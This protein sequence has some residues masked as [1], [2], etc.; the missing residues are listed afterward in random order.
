M[1]IDDSFL[2]KVDIFPGEQ[3]HVLNIN[4]G[5]SFCNLCYFSTARVRHRIIELTG[6]QIRYC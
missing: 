4:N 3:V 6:G 5:K 1:T 2:E